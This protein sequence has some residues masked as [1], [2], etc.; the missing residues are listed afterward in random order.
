[1]ALDRRITLHL[2]E[3]GD[4]DDSGRFV[5]GVETDH[6]IWATLIPQPINRDVLPGGV[7][8]I[9]L[10]QW[11]IRWRSDLADTGITEVSIS[12]DGVRYIVTNIQEDNGRFGEVRHRFLILDGTAETT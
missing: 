8:T 11:R 2:R 9:T 10:Q 5:P 6:G 12:A 4:Y 3:Q 1:M 7:R